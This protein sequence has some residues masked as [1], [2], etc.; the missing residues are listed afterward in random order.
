MVFLFPL[1][2]VNG[3]EC[4]GDLFFVVFEYS[5]RERLCS[6]IAPRGNDSLLSSV[7]EIIIYDD[8]LAIMQF[9]QGI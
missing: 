2:M 7:G 1:E 4:A 6:R 5:A 3:N 8:L 9:G